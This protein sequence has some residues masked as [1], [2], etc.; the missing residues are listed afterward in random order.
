[1]PLSWNEIR[2][3]ATK[4]SKEWEDATDEDAD[5]KSFWDALFE[6]YGVPRKRFATFEKRVDH[7]DGKRGFIDLLWHKVVLVEHKSKGKNLDRAHAQAK[8]YFPGIKDRDLPRFIVVCDFDRFRV[9]DL[10]TD[11]VTEFTLKELPNKIQALGFIAGYQARVFKEQDPVNI[12]AAVKLGKLH[13]ELKAVGYAGHELEVYLVRLLFCLFADDTGI[14]VPRDIFQ[15]YITQRTSEDGSDLGPRLS[16]LFETMN[17]PVEERYKVLDD[18][19]KQFPYVNGA[20]FREQLPTAPFTSATRGALLECCETDWGQISPAIFGSLFQSI[21]DDVQRRDLGAHYTSEQNILKAIQPLFLDALKAEFEAIKTQRAKLPAFHDKLATLHF[22]DPACG[23][24]NFLVI[25]YREL[26]MLELDVIRTLHGKEKQQLALDAIRDYVKVDVDQFHGIEIEE[27]PAQIARVALWLMDHQMNVL[28][29]QEFGNALVRVPLVKSANIANGNALTTDWA[30]VLRPERCTFLIGNPPFVGAKYMTDAQRESSRLV[31]GSMRNAGLLDFVAAWYVK[32]AHYM[33]AAPL[34]SRPRCAFVSTNS[35]TQ[36]EQ[37]APLWGWMLRQGVKIHFAHRT[38]CWT[39]EARGKAAV[40]CVIIGF[41]IDDAG[42]SKVIFEYDDIKGDPHKVAVSNINPY[43]V[44]FDD[45][46]LENRSRPICDVPTIGIG[47]KPIDGG[48]YL[49]SSDERKEFVALEPAAAPFFKRWIGSEEFLN[50]FE[51]WCLWLGDATPD[52]LRN[53]PH[54][55]KRV[56]A[57]KKVRLDSKSPPTQKLAEKPR[58]FHVEN[59]PTGNWMA[60]PETSSMRRRYVPLG[61]ESPKTLGSNLL[62]ILPDATLYHFGVMSSLMHNVWMAYT[63]GR[64]KSDYRYS[65]GIVY[66][67]FPWPTATDKQTAAIEAAAQVVLKERLKFKK[68][69]LAELYDPLTMPD[70]LVNAHRALDSI[71]DAA[72]GRKSFSKDAERIAFLMGKYTALH[73]TLGLVAASKKAAR[74]VAPAKKAAPK[75]EEATEN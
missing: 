36:G 58:R 2:T 39:N 30:S 15:D 7:G 20:L 6:V 1:L 72:Y 35:I 69:T 27:W 13:D 74:K 22:F 3:R 68:A 70:E 41:G 4:F 44:D 61:F 26:R 37:V 73:N 64:M 9:T 59:M 46:V 57:V 19:L 53:M 23:C 52:Q 67:N 51:R 24:G 8:G 34:G 5:A 65:V 25:A 12:K 38:F 33:R 43:L 56:E 28:V 62:K 75:R 48:N 10:E 17:R 16:E 63:C 21:M 14:F 31:F 11:D 18:A 50:G 49:F 55:R 29:S 40:H 42:V 66:N 45:L 54:A 60:I 71:V 47:N 32:A